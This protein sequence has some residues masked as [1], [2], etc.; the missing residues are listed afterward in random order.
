MERLVTAVAAAIRAPSLHNSQPWRFVVRAD[1]VDVRLDPARR[2]DVADPD[3]SAARIACGAAVHNLTLAFP[4][5]LGREADVT[6]LPDRSD[7]DLVARLRPGQARPATPRERAGYAAIPRRRTNRYP[8]RDDVPV[9]PGQYW[10]LGEVARAEHG[11]LTVITDAD[12][13]R[14]IGAMV[15]EADRTLS[16]DPAYRAELASWVR[17]DPHTDDG[18]P[19]ASA[20]IRPEVGDPLRGRDYGGRTRRPGRGFEAEPLLAVLGGPGE[21]AADQITVGRALQAVLLAATEA[22]LAVSL[23]SQPFEVPAMRARLRRLIDRLGA[24]YLVLRIGYPSRPSP[25]T[26]RRPPPAVVDRAD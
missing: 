8:F 11:W 5:L 12:R 4:V 13:R 15:A 22:G 21:R 17:R 20:G 6:V 23:Y 26:P 16:A 1:R 9:Q 3:G 2:L 24:P 7:P 25:T 18:V 14:R 10:A 19:T